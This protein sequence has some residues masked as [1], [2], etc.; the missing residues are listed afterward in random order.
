MGF[1]KKAFKK[2]GK[3]FKSAFKSIGKGIKSAM[4]KIGK[5]MGKIGI[6]GQ[7]ALMFTPVGAMMSNMF[8]GIGQAAGGVFTKVTGAL[9]KG[10]QLAQGA[11]KI[12]EAG[13]NF[14]KA[15]HSA[16]KTVTDGVSSFVS[17]FSK[18]AL[19]KIPGM[20]TM[21]PSLK[22]AS[23]TFFA[24]PNSAWSTVQNEV[25]T[26][27]TA[28]LDNFNK[29]I[30]KAPTVTTAAQQNLKLQAEKQVATANTGASDSMYDNKGFSTEMKTDYQERFSFK[31]TDQSMKDLAASTSSQPVVGR[32]SSV[33]GE[34]VKAESLLS[35]A[36]DYVKDKYTDFLDGRDFKT[37]AMEETVD[38]GQEQL[39]T[40]PDELGR[41]AK[42]R[43]YQ[44]V[45]LKAKAQT[46][47]NQYSSFVP[48]F[49]TAPAGA[50]ASADIN[51]RAMQMQ[52]TG[53]DF[54]QQSPF[55]AGAHFY[56]QQMARSIGGTV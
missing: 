46:T 7:L 51:D 24:G 22:G 11:G 4:G 10:G 48:E 53:S 25:M 45:G 20:Q 36:G 41:E 33:T 13:A 52:V 21:M 26:N 6:V 43:L 29:A 16:F 12:L 39:G 37:A 50:Y 56:T 44:N 15:G 27:A 23:D 8:A 19:K 14:A 17:E 54:Y 31:N 9:A 49:T 18:T 30:G 1:F 32:V 2:I 40:I 47:V 34:T 3:G 38:W 28:V 42:T 55:G 5:F 35:Q